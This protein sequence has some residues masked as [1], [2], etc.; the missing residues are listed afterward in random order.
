MTTVR[1]ATFN[2]ENFDETGD[3]ERP[4]LD[5][6]IVLM[7]PQIVRLRADV[8]CFQE[9]N[10]QE[11]PGQPRALLALQ[12]L[13]EGTNLAGANLVSSK[14]DNDGVYDERNLVVATHHQVLA[15]EQLRNKLV[16][17][18]MYLRLTAV[19][20]DTEAT[21]IGIERPILHV[22][23]DTGVAIL[24]V[25][26]VHLKSKIPTDIPGQKLD[27]FT[28]KT[29]E[30][31]AEGVFLSSMK[32]MSQ[33]LEVRRLVDTILTADPDAMI[34]VAG[35]FNATPDE[36]PVQAIRGAVEN[37]GNGDLARR[38]LVPIENTVPA[39]SRYTLYHQGRGEMLDHMLVTRN[40]LAGYRGSEIHN[41]VLHDESAAFA[42]DRK[43]PE[44]DHAPVVATFEFDA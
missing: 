9:V 25:I 27:G 20:P 37:T 2:L 33:A 26:N 15:R 18:P 3:G 5:E 23:I 42:I 16:A 28:W 32:R 22:T 7:R 29:A 36:V 10:G 17:E 40:M 41:E 8:A 24:H 1:I 13:L 12:R 35:D 38:V 43:Y 30:A 14:P 4:S 31:W 39:S 44:S 34:I 19:P 21:P 6:R 11:R